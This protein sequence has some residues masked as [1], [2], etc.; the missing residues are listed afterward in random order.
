MDALVLIDIQTGFD[1][2]T[3]GDRNNPFAEDRAGLLLDRWRSSGQPVVHV[4]HVSNAP[5]SPLSGDGTQFKPQVAPKPDELIIEKSVNSAFIG[6]DLNERLLA[7]GATALTLCGLTTPHCVSTTTRMAANLGFKTR[8]V[9]DACA[10]FTSNADVSFDDGPALTADEI[11]R[12]ALAHLH[13]EFAHV[14][15]SEEV[16]KDSAYPASGLV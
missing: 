4:R 6:T 11:H 16:L 3:W 12:T 10:A 7:L 1:D 15:N 5:G 14:C 9:A 2:P 8:L 13:G